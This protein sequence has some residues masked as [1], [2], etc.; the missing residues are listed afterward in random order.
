MMTSLTNIF[1]L[2]MGGKSTQ[3][4]NDDIDYCSTVLF[5]FYFMAKMM[6]WFQQLFLVSVFPSWKPPR[7]SHTDFRNQTNSNKANFAVAHHRNAAPNSSPPP[8]HHFC[9]LYTTG[10]PSPQPLLL[11]TEPI[12]YEENHSYKQI[13]NDPCTKLYSSLSY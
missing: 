12:F 7:C 3:I 5:Y 4:I 10:K 8:P 1:G 13:N 9:L 2:E 6:C 11:T